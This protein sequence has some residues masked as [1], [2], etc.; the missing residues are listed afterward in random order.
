MPAFVHTEL[1]IRKGLDEAWQKEIWREDEYFDIHLYKQRKSN[2]Q[3]IRRSRKEDRAERTGARGVRGQEKAKTQRARASGDGAKIE[4]PDLYE[5]TKHWLEAERSHGHVVLPRHVSWK[6][7]SS[8]VDEIARSEARM[9]EEENAQQRRLLKDR[10]GRGKRQKMSLE[11]PKNQE[12]RAKHLMSWMGAKVQTPN[13]VTQ[14]SE[15]EQQVRAEL[16]WNQFDFQTWQMSSKKGELYHEMFAQPEK[17][18]KHVHQCALGFS[19]QIP[20]WV[21]KPSSKEVFAG[22][23]LRTSAKS[24]SVHRQE[25]REQL[26]K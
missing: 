11:K 26:A 3:R 25:I 2:G 20:L 13:L 21:K 10:I 24:V 22:F 17:A 9:K 1:C 23:E 5:K 8:L 14:L 16:T 7:E 15:V 19:D 18:K 6:Y 4:F 12:R